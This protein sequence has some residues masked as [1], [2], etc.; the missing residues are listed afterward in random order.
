M[1]PRTHVDEEKIIREV[2]EEEEEKKK[3][4]EAAAVESFPYYML[5]C[6]ADTLDWTLMVLGTLGSVVHGM[7]QPFGYLLLGKALNAYGENLNDIN[8]MV[9]A[10]KHV[11]NKKHKPA[12]NLKPKLHIRYIFMTIYVLFCL[13][14]CL[15]VLRLFPTYGTW[16]LLHS[17]LE[18]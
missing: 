11:K 2:A 12:L 14:F 4:G 17:Q 13:V 6:Y 1:A 9:K 15:Y 10:L 8:G 18:Y 7:A 16:L 5:L 3:N